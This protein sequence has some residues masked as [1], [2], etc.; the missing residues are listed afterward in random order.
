VCDSSRQQWSDT[1]SQWPTELTSHSAEVF[2]QDI[3]AI[4]TRWD[5]AVQHYIVFRQQTTTS[6]PELE[7]SFGTREQQERK[8][9]TEAKATPQAMIEAEEAPAQ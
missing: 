7:P 6:V 2:T 5:T 1:K 9:A 3:D 4:L 8:G